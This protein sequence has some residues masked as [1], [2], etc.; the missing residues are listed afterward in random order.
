MP[1]RKL[2]DKANDAE[3]EVASHRDAYNQAWHIDS[4]PSVPTTGTSSKQQSSAVVIDKAQ[5][6]INHSQAAVAST[7]QPATTSTGSGSKWQSIDDD[8]EIT[9]A[10]G[11]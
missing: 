11:K 10:E 2:R 9:N 7:A 4:T 8:E 1:S 5:A 6:Q 3:P